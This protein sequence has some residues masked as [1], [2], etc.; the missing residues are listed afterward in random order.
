[1]KEKIK[2]FLK[3][4]YGKWIIAL[5]IATGGGAATFQMFSTSIMHS[6]NQI[7]NEA[8][9]ETVSELENTEVVKKAEK[10]FD[11][12][13]DVSEVIKQKVNKI[14]GIIEQDQ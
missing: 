7:V 2:K 9:N 3:S 4:R 14:S 8:I 10:A 11:N 5:V 13:S 1:M 12:V 6:V